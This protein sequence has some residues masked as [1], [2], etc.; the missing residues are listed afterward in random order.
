MGGGFEV[1]ALRA[2]IMTTDSELAAYALALEKRVDRL[3]TLEDNPVS[4]AG[5]WAFIVAQELT[6]AA[7]SIT[8]DSIP[9]TYDDLMIIWRARSSKAGV[10]NR[11]EFTMQFNGDTIAGN[12]DAATQGTGYKDGG[13]LTL[14]QMISA[15]ATGHADDFSVG[16][17]YLPEYTNTT[18]K[19]SGNGMM[20][21]YGNT[22][23]FALNTQ[24]SGAWA[25]SPYPA[26]TSIKFF[27]GVSAANLLADTHIEL[28]GLTR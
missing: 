22:A 28:Y 5:V 26:I 21:G 23:V 20:G 27:L 15:A 25:K 14:G 19:A 6:V 9:Q 10:P 2:N 1:L 3:K 18:K 12:Y 24:S 17:F 16:I 11:D 7:A 8:F 13:F 4:A